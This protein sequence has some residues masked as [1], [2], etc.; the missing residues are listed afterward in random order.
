MRSCAVLV[1]SCLERDGSEDMDFDVK[2]DSE[3]GCDN[4]GSDNEKCEDREEG[5]NQLELDQGEG[6]KVS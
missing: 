1:G 3:T 2:E 6:R 5:T 4:K